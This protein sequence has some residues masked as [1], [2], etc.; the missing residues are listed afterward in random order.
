MQFFLNISPTVSNDNF[1]LETSSSI[2]HLNL[3]TAVTEATLARY[4]IC[5]FFLFFFFLNGLN[6]VV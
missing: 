5:W 4:R 2:G 1:S 3:T 6:A